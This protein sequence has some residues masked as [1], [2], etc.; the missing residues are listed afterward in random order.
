MQEDISFDDMPCHSFLAFLNRLCAMPLGGKARSAAAAKSKRTEQ[1]LKKLE[2]IRKQRR[3]KG[4]DE[5]EDGDD[6]GGFILM[7]EVEQD[8][9]FRLK[10]LYQGDVLREDVSKA[11]LGLY[12][13]IGSSS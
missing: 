5:V 10:L 7:E 3:A 1:A 6:G 12:L 2:R 4:G 9:S 13:A 11:S 8:S